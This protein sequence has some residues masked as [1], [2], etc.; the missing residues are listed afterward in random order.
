MRYIK[1]LNIFVLF[2]YSL[3]FA[4]ESKK[5]PEEIDIRKE[6]NIILKD[7]YCKYY[8]KQI[9]VRS[10]DPITVR[11]LLELLAYL[12]KDDPHIYPGFENY[13]LDIVPAEDDIDT[14]IKQIIDSYFCQWFCDQLDL[15]S[16]DP[17]VA[18]A[19]MENI[20]YFHEKFKQEPY[21]D[22]YNALKHPALLP[23]QMIHLIPVDQLKK[24]NSCAL[25]MQLTEP[26]LVTIF[27]KG[28][29]VSQ[30]LNTKDVACTGSYTPPQKLYDKTKH[31]L[32]QLHAI[33]Q[34]EI[35]GEYCPGLSVR[36]AL[37]LQKFVQ[38]GDVALLKQL[39][40]LSSA[41]E[42]IDKTGCPKVAYK[43]EVIAKVINPMV[44]S[45]GLS[46][47]SISVIES[48]MVFNPLQLQEKFTIEERKAA[49]ELQ[50]KIQKG[51]QE[52][53]FFHAF[54]V[55]NAEEQATLHTQAHWYCV[56]VIKLNDTIQYVIIDTIPVYH[57]DPKPYL[58]KPIDS[59][60]YDRI[61]YLIDLLEQGSSTIA[62]I[63]QPMTK[64][65]EQ[66]IE[67]E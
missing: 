39:Y 2:F 42:F 53:Y 23:K 9:P 7:K 61:R 63:R 20:K 25:F 64:E 38:T 17:M 6:V 14:K 67:F 34:T 46:A 24:I 58:S 41:Q 62:L 48:V 30:Y 31:V 27:E 3:S 50:A 60:Q 35:G 4:L 49:L 45:M 8:S 1:L 16:L 32:L 59:L 26:P 47:Q 10:I 13:L 28:E 43:E 40:D 66:L 36:N 22:F 44:R 56:C 37:I 12:R 57:L 15:K 33:N 21:K 11:N 65:E 18:R 55:G 51:L 54:I 19:L 5:L 52:P 29:W